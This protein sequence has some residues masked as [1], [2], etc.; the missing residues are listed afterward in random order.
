MTESS[1]G[2]SLGKGVGKDLS[3]EVTFELRPKE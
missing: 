1:G 3:T 2:T